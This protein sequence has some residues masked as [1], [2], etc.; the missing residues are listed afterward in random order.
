MA[1][2]FQPDVIKT[3]QPSDISGLIGVDQGDV[4]KIMS[5]IF[6]MLLY[7]NPGDRMESSFA[8]I[9]KID[10]TLIHIDSRVNKSNVI[11]FLEHRKIIKIPA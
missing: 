3:I 7:M 2:A 6:S 5:L 1:L 9:E 4:E 10:A 11:D 8:L